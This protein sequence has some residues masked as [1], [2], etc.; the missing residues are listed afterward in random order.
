MTLDRRVL[1]EMTCLGHQA[2]VQPSAGTSHN[3][4]GSDSST[5]AG[6]PRC[7]ADRRHGVLGLRE[8][9]GTR[10]STGMCASFFV[11]DQRRFD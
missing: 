3:R 10:F 9:E 4:L 7:W 1:R 2:A 6:M 8:T 5:A 11:L